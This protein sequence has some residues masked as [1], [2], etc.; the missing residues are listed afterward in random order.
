M[1]SWVR[2][3]G[4]SSLLQ[5]EK[6]GNCFATPEEVLDSH[7]SMQTIN[8]P[9][10]MTTADQNTESVSNSGQGNL[11]LLYNKKTDQALIVVIAKKQ[12]W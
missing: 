8:K 3:E 6:G 2:R 4:S 11:L 12:T 7:G 1:V 9:Y 5:P 10:I